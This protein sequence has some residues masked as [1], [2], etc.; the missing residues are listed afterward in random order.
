MEISI[1]NCKKCLGKFSEWLSQIP[2]PVIREFAGALCNAGFSTSSAYAGSLSQ[3]IIKYNA[4]RPEPTLES[5]GQKDPTTQHIPPIK[6]FLS[7]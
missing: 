6:S 4:I 3:A 2:P 7:N 1:W 5:K